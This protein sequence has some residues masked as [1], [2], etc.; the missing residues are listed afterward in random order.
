MKRILFV[1]ATAVL[2]INTLVTPVAVRAD[3]TPIGGGPG[4]PLAAR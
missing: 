4:K 1:L 3:G 2:F